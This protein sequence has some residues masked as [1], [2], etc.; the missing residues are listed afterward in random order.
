MINYERKRE[1][2]KGQILDIFPEG[3]SAFRACVLEVIGGDEEIA[4]VVNL[5]TGEVSMR[6][7]WECEEPII[8]NVFD[9]T[10]CD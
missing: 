4:R 9:L 10:E 7:H 3:G 5:D 2:M 1:I 8:E 6:H